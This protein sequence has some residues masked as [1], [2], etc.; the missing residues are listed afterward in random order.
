MG[1]WGLGVRKE[2]TLALLRG[3]GDGEDGWGGDGGEGFTC[4]F[5]VGFLKLP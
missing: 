5:T 1:V 2:G 3:R 4:M